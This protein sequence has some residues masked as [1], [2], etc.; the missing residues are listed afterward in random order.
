MRQSPEQHNRRDLDQEKLERLGAIYDLVTDWRDLRLML[1]SGRS[2]LPPELFMYL[3]VEHQDRTE[4]RLPYIE[5][6]HGHPIYRE[7]YALL[8]E[9]RP[10]N[11]DAREIEFSLADPSGKLVKKSR[12]VLDS[13]GMPVIREVPRR[14]TSRNTGFVTVKEF[15]LLLKEAAD[16]LEAYSEPGQP[17]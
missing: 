11:D 5:L 2:H 14:A 6:A 16:Y 9:D 8:V 7:D 4:C 3:P 12:I 1:E 10:L 17:K 15:H 13:A